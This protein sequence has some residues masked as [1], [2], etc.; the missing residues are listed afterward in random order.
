VRID[1][2]LFGVLACVL[3]IAVIRHSAGFPGVPGQYYGAALFPTVIGWG[4][5]ACGLVLLGAGLRRAGLSGA[6]M[7][8]PDW[9]GSLRGLLGVAV[10]LGAIV[11]FALLGDL[12]GFQILA[13]AT[14]TL[15]YLIAGRSVVRSIGAALVVTIFMELLFGKLLRVPLPRGLLTDLPWF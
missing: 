4:F 11:A 6:M 5:V 14:L 12:V 13:F 15:L 1:D 2:R 3:G 8:F 7:A 9:I 10:M